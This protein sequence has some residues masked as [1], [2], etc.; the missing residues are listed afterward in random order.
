MHIPVP[1]FINCHSNLTNSKAKNKM[2][3][4]YY[5]THIPSLATTNIVEGTDTDTATD[6]GNPDQTKGL[7]ERE[8]DGEDMGD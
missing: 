7:K 4:M 2:R 3:K 1:F 5:K 6:K 8:R